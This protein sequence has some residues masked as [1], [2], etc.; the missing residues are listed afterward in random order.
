MEDPSVSQYFSQFNPTPKQLRRLTR[1]LKGVHKWWGIDYGDSIIKATLVVAPGDLAHLTPGAIH[2]LARCRDRLREFKVDL[3]RQYDPFHKQTYRDLFDLLLSVGLIV[4]ASPPGKLAGSTTVTDLRLMLRAKGLSDKGRKDDLVNRVVSNCTSDELDKMVAEVILYRATPAGDH[5]LQAIADLQ[6]TMGQA[7]TAAVTETM[8][9]F[10]ASK[11]P[12]PTLP[13][14]VYYDDGEVR[15]TQE[16]IDRAVGV[17]VDLSGS[18]MRDILDP[19]PRERKG[20][21]R[22]RLLPELESA[23]STGGNRRH[24]ALSYEAVEGIVCEIETSGDGFFIVST[25]PQNDAPFIQAAFSNQ[26]SGQWHIEARAD[27]TILSAIGFVQGKDDLLP[28]KRIQR[29]VSEIVIETLRTAFD[30]ALGAQVW[31]DVEIPPSLA[32]G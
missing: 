29:E 22:G 26:P 1:L 20:K 12:A 2:L 7:F 23:A 9:D 10:E 17:T 25:T 3:D 6:A 30:I 13:S 21:K 5:A 11:E 18:E 31:V 19:I 8:A 4:D 15:I 28:T 27:L 32:R 24:M 14:G 16:D